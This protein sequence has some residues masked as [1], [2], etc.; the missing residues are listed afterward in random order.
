MDSV[1]RIE[2]DGTRISTTARLFLAARIPPFASDR[3]AIGTRTI[4]SGLSAR[5]D[6]F[7]ERG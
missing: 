1:E 2:R 6:A 3:I 7:Q 5:M 4:R